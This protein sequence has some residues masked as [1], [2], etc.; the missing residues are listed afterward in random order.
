MGDFVLFYKAP[1]KKS[2]PRW[3]GPAA[4]LDIDE[5]GAALKFQ[6]QTFKVARHCVQR[7]LDKKDL[8]QGSAAG[9]SQLNIGWVMSKPLVRPSQDGEPWELAP[10]SEESSKA[11]RKTLERETQSTDSTREAPVEDATEVSEQ[12]PRP[13]IRFP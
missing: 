2:N 11:A 9:D 5:F 8:P 3:R 12:P 13:E 6:S 10:L 1:R 4:I 7:K